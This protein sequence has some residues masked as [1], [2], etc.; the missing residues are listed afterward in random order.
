MPFFLVTKTSLVE[1]Q[2]EQEA[3]QVGVERLRSGGEV[4]VS[5]K[6]DETTI[7]HVVIGAV[8]EEPLPVSLSEAAD[9]PR[10][11]AAIAEAGPAAP[12]SRK[13]ILKR[14]LADGLALLGRRT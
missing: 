12:E 3:A 14:V 9:P 8:V 13:L 6:S 1:A 11:A 7:T 2:D 4:T 5:V 10:A